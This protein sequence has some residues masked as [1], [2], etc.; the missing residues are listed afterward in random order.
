MATAEAAETAKIGSALGPWGPALE[1]AGSGVGKLI[2]ILSKTVGDRLH[3]FDPVKDNDSPLWGYKES[4]QPLT[5]PNP[6]LK[7]E[8][9]PDAGKPPSKEEA[10]V[11]AIEVYQSDIALEKSIIKLTSILTNEDI[12]KNLEIAGEVLKLVDDIQM[13]REEPQEPGKPE[14]IGRTVLE[15]R[16]KTLLDQ[17]GN[18]VRNGRKLQHV[19]NAGENPVT[20][21]KATAPAEG[22]NAGELNKQIKVSGNNLHCKQGSTS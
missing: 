6:V 1:A 19:K 13:S 16:T 15:P 10:V 21:K 14:N 17:L 7:Q 2:K 12:E 3:K 8:Y 22:G 5:V 20:Q 9:T 4:P 11:K 18:G